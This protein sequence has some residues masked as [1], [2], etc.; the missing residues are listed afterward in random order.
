MC[1]DSIEPHFIKRLRALGN[2]G[3]IGATGVGLAT[4]H[5]DTGPGPAS[6]RALATGDNDVIATAGDTTSNLVERQAGDGNT[7]VCGTM[8]VT[9]IVVLFDKNAVP[10]ER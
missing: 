9:T 10:E 8:E 3:Y 5:G 2:T 6:A 1:I 7:G 4:S